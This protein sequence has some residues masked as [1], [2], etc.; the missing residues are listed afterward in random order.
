MLEIAIILGSTR[1][2]R[3]GEGVARWVYD[4]AA[5]RSDAHYD[6]IDIKDQ[7]LPLLDEPAPPSL[8]NYS[9]PHTKAW[10]AKIGSTMGLCLSPPNTTTAFP[11]RS[12][13]PSTTFTKSGTTR[14]REYLPR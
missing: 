13:T 6:L 1:P 10:A 7:N 3:I 9:Q 2:N 11:A 14:R 4:I 8:G 12:R 5:R